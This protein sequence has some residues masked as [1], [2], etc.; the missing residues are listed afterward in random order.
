[1]ITEGRGHFTM[2]KCAP[3]SGQPAGWT[4]PA[5]APMEET[6]VRKVLPDFLRDDHAYQDGSP[7]EG[8]QGEPWI[9]RFPNV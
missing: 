2:Q 1:M 3:R 9:P 7:E 4:W 8:R 5:E 6:E